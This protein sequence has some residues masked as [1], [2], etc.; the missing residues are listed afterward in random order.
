MVA[1]DVLHFGLF[2]FSFFGLQFRRVAPLYLARDSP[3]TLVSYQ[4]RILFIST[5][6][7]CNTGIFQLGTPV[8]A[9]RV[10]RT[11]ASPSD[12][13]ETSFLRAENWQKVQNTTKRS[14]ATQDLAL[15]TLVRPMP[16]RLQTIGTGR[17]RPFHFFEPVYVFGNAPINPAPDLCTH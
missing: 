13:T 17:R 4:H 2:W 10:W 1:Q 8:C 12:R 11:R 16:K 7:T 5:P 15:C 14:G 3:S 6:A 9:S